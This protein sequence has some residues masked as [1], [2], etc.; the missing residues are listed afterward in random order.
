MIL[1]PIKV[2]DVGQFRTIVGSMAQES[3]WSEPTWQYTTV[4][5][6][7]TGM[8]EQAAVS[9]ADLVMVCGGDGTVREVCAELAGTGIPVGIIPA[10]TGNLLARNLDIPLYL[11]SAID[12]ALNGQDRA[13]DLVNG[14][15]RRH[16]GHPLHGDGRDGLRRR[17]HGGRQRGHQE[18]DRLGRLRHLRRSSR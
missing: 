4:E 2:E 6:P 15:R 16:R 8:A 5:D 11:R 12:V 17:D 18:A 7:G 14:R 10:G 1:N 3:G 9:G 13:I